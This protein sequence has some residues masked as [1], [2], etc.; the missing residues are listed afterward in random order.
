M[1]R[2]ATETQARRPGGSAR[3]VEVRPGASAAMPSVR[4]RSG[5]SSTPRSTSSPRGASAGAAR[6]GGGTGGRRQGHHLPVLP[7]EAGAVRGADP[8]RHRRPD[9]S[10]G[11]R[12]GGA[13]P[14]LRGRRAHALHPHAPRDPRHPAQGDRPPRHRR[15]GALPRDRRVL[16]PRGGGRGMALL[17][18]CRRAGG[19]AR[20]AVLRRARPLSPARRRAG[21]RRLPVGEPVRALRAARR[22]GHARGASRASD[23]RPRRRST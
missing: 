11:R 17:R 6:G 2:T 19:R 22:R 8:H 13:R 12:G 18:A 1:K 21:P 9:R 23:A 5:R 20:R 3:A 16:L 14:S 15:S 10:G 4:P 7:V